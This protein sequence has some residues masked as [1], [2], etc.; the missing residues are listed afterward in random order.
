VDQIFGQ[1]G[2]FHS[3]ICFEQMMKKEE[4]VPFMG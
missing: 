3:S 4:V 1:N 2:M